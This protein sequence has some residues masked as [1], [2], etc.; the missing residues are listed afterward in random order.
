MLEG[1]FQQG[2]TAFYLPSRFTGG[3]YHVRVATPP[4]YAAGTT[5]Y[6]LLVVLDGAM[7]FG[8]AVEAAAIQAMTGETRPIIIA[9]VSTRGT[10]A[11]HNTQRLRDFTPSGM[12][13]P[14]AG[15]IAANPVLQMLG[16]RF[17]AAGLDFES[18]LGG[19]EA[20]PVLSGK[21]IATCSA[22]GLSGR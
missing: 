12:E 19:A 7:V 11:E 10:L 6:P 2:T 20:F 13:D 5:S 16:R 8:T 15:V 14:S 18:A 9:A 21:G 1:S 4:G 17:E 3:E 22:A